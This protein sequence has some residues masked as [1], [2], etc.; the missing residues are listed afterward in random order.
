MSVKLQAAKDVRAMI[1]VI[2]K[3]GPELDR[4]VHDCA[5]QC[6]AHAKEHGD[7]TLVAELVGGKF[8]KKGVVTASYDGVLV[9][10]GYGVGDLKSWIM[11]HTPIRFNNSTGNI[12]IPKEKNKEENWKLELAEANPFFTHPDYMRRTVARAPFSMNSL[13]TLVQGMIKRI[14]NA[15]AD[16]KLEGDPEAM[17][18]YAKALMEVKTPEEDPKR[19]VH[20]KPANEEVPVTIDNTTAVSPEATA[21]NTGNRQAA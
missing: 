5:V 7:L 9:Q 13:E 18:A 3:K 10:T 20:P 17:R 15:L 8:I 6:M 12:G 1:K 4:L 14:D 21:G 16:G 11:G 2:A 19:V